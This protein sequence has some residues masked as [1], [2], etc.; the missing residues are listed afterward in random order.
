VIDFALRFWIREPTLAVLAAVKQV[1]GDVPS[2]L[3]TAAWCKLAERG[4]LRNA[5]ANASDAG[6]GL[7]APVAVALA[8]RADAAHP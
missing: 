5:L 2:V 7:G 3:D 4:L 8:G 6:I 1:R